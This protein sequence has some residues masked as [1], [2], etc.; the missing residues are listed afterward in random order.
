MLSKNGQNGD[1]T[2]SGN[3]HGQFWYQDVVSSCP[4]FTVFLK[5]NPLQGVHLE[6][7]GCEDAE[8][9]ESFC[10]T[11]LISKSPPESLL[12]GK[13]SENQTFQRLVKLLDDATVHALQRNRPLLVT[14]YLHKSKDAKSGLPVNRTERL[15]LQALSMRAVAPDLVIDLPEAVTINTEIKKTSKQ[16]KKYK[17]KEAP[18]QAA[19]TPIVA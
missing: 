17:R 12:P 19:S 3:K 13:E 16:V 10:N 9:L 7:P 18:L 6:D 8:A 4:L 2:N 15:C 11:Q 14:A 5:R 1:S